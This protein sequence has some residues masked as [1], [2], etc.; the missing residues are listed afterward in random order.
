MI[1]KLL[2]SRTAVALVLVGIILVN[3]F[4][5]VHNEE[6]TS[7]VNSKEGLDAAI[8]KVM[9]D[10]YTAALKEE[11]L[12]AKKLELV[13]L[14]KEDLRK[15]YKGKVYDEVQKTVEEK[16]RLTIEADIRKEMEKDFTKKYF[17]LRS[18][19]YEFLTEL[20]QKYYNDNKERF[21]SLIAL[22]SL[23]LV[24]ENEKGTDQLKQKVAGEIDVLASRKEWYSFVLKDLI[25]QSAPKMG[26]LTEK[27]LGPNLKGC[28]FST[29]LPIYDKEMLS[30]VEFSEERM[31]DFKT[32]HESLVLKLLMMG[33]PPAN[34]FNGEGIVISG[35]G[36]YM[37]GAMAA[38][39]QV[40][41]MGSRLPIELL[42]NSQ[43][44]YDAYICEDLG[45]KFN[46]RCLIIEDEIG[47]DV[48]KEL[49]ITKFQ[50]KILG[51]LVTSFDHVIALDADN[52]PLK[53]P[54]LLLTT[55]KYQE[56]EFLLWPD[57]WQRT[58]SLSYYEIAGLRPGEVVKR[59]GLEN[60][61]D[62]IDY[63]NR[64]RDKVHFHDLDGIPDHVSTETGQMVFSKKKHYRAFILA[65]YYNIYG[66]THYW[67]MFYQG[68]PGEGDRDTFVPALHVFNEPY[69]VVERATWLAGFK[70]PDGFFQETTIVQYDPETSYNYDQAWKRWLSDKGFDLRMHFNQNNDYTRKLVKEFHGLTHAVPEPEVFF[71]HV[72]RPKVNPVFLTNPE[73]Y[74][75]WN[76]QRNLGKVGE[77]K[78]Q[79]GETDWDLKFY[80]IA[81]WVAC[82]GIKSED[83]WKAVERTQTLVCNS[84]TE[85]VEFLKKDSEDKTAQTFVN[86]VLD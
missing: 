63:L 50:L 19:N 38:I 62:L 81:Q 85:Y 61:K 83:W 52:M 4:F 41:E 39:V 46:F 48:V 26:R 49:K 71:L 27:E 22:E 16:L 11:L 30:R 65:L 54:D 86:V 21:K 43:Q 66:E 7:P 56:T 10:E 3:L 77:Y 59:N 20:K 75:D 15:E 13:E 74:F 53:N 72:H 37:A 84:M 34:V 68:S 24:L 47:A 64:G 55:P 51:L 33:A 73:G 69:H 44:E 70:R 78:S 23:N 29:S 8:D 6:N 80:T 28:Q 57:L 17:Y 42:I 79:F 5:V 45:E 67:R 76:K 14:V 25:Q 82:K 36:A 1:S 9:S 35:G 32:N 60:G 2:A 31:A 40:R 18:I 58:V 12:D